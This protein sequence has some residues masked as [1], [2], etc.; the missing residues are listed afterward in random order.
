MMSLILSYLAQMRLKYFL[1]SIFIISLIG[2]AIVQ[3]QY[4]RI[5]LNLASVQFSR[6]VE[7][8]SA[9]IKEELRSE[10]K[11]TFLVVSAI[12]K[13]TTFFTTSIDSLNQSAKLFLT[14]F[15]KDRLLKNGVDADFAYELKNKDSIVYLKSTNQFSKEDKVFHHSIYLEGYLPDA[16]N[17]DLVLNL[18]FQNLNLYFLSKL[19]GLTL[20]SLIFLVCILLIT[21]WGFK[22]FYWQQRVI[23]TTDDFIN[24]LTHELKTPVY[25]IQ[26]ATKI[27]EEKSKGEHK[28][29]LTIIQQQTKRLSNHIEKVLE[30]ASMDKKK[31]GILLKPI[32][33]YPVLEK[34]CKE[35]EALV[36]L[37]QVMFTYQ[38]EGSTYPIL[39]E[40]FHLENAIKNLLDNAKKY[41]INPKIKLI[42]L[43]KQNLLVIRV[44]DNGVGIDKQ[45]IHKVF[46]KYYRSNQ[47][48]LHGVK[49]FGLG[50]NYAHTVIDKHKGKINLE[51][52][53]NVG[54]VVTVKIP[55]YER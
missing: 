31:T 26:L 5:G 32:D 36:S 3:Y 50:L 38:L 16:I 27:L 30:L 10:N 9:T 45:D 53:K 43:Q 39:G 2:L 19:N 7:V 28:T 14:D 25:S 22:T 12:K 37:E 6:K 18:N 29:F 42:A 55:L 11:L 35:F 54:T 51:S 44:E 1:I 8:A 15:V 21:I 49:G 24:N 20:P 52:S 46:Q 47:S 17:K 40:A 34:L 4:L 41:A 33:F 13:D 23:A 48:N